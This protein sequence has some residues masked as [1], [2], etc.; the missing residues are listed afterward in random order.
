M[1][2]VKVL[3]CKPIIVLECKPIIVRN[4]VRSNTQLQRPG[5]QVT[6]GV[7][8]FYGEGGVCFFLSI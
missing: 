8:V 6:T 7:S 3:E 1:L 2:A 5:L 4:T